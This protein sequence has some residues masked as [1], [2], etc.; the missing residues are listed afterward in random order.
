MRKLLLALT[1]AAGAVVA[2]PA[3]QAA[4]RLAPS[5]APVASPL[6]GLDLPDA[7]APVQYYDDHRYRRALRREAYE[8][9][10]RREA[11][12]EWRHRNGYYGRPYG[13][14]GYPRYGYRY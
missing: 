7:V 2:A 10:L 4:P 14:G 1:L 3:A 12:R 9:H 5:M 6:A 11:R 8:R 13:Y